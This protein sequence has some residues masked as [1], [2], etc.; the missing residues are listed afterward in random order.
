MET[1]LIEGQRQGTHQNCSSLATQFSFHPCTKSNRRTTWTRR[2]SPDRSWARRRR[3]RGGGRGVAARRWEEATCLSGLVVVWLAHR[4]PSPDAPDKKNCRDLVG[5]H[6]DTRLF[7]SRHVTRTWDSRE[8]LASY[9]CPC[10]A[11]LASEF[12]THPGLI[13]H[14]ATSSKMFYGQSTGSDQNIYSQVITPFT[15]QKKVITPFWDKPKMLCTTSDESQLCT[16]IVGHVPKK[17]NKIENTKKKKG[18]KHHMPMS[19]CWN[20]A[21]PINWDLATPLSFS[22]QMSD[23]TNKSES[24]N[25]KTTRSATRR[26]KF[27]IFGVSECRPMEWCSTHLL[28]VWILQ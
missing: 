25:M 12:H 2:N 22:F 21:K 23:P 8:V 17:K 10:R 1:Q 3:P 6:A 13:R 14:Y 5:L 28:D 11:Y 19:V 20:L 4:A 16:S 18:A 26:H 27:N 15:C 7:A 24:V 9:L